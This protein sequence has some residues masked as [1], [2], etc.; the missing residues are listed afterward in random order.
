MKSELYNDWL[1]TTKERKTQKSR[2]KKKKENQNKKERRKKTRYKQIN[3]NTKKRF[4][5][6]KILYSMS[7]TK[8]I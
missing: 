8:K 7:I 1:K 2:L 3:K 6:W 4:E 5:R